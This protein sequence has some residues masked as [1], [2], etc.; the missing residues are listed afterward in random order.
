MLIFYLYHYLSLKNLI[1]TVEF[2]LYNVPV[3][4]GRHHLSQKYK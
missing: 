2:L 1:S 3:R 4:Q